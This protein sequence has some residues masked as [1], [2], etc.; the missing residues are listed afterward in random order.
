MVSVIQWLDALNDPPLLCIGIS[1]LFASGWW[2]ERIRR[3]TE[4]ARLI[5]SSIRRMELA[6]DLAVLERK[7]MA[8][9]VQKEALG[10]R[11]RESARMR[12]RGQC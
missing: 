11:L 2:R 9:E 8:L 6:R 5:V 12:G 1:G 10:S 7:M 4:G 3:R